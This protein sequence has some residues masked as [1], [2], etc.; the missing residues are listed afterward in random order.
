M[1]NATKY[2]VIEDSTGLIYPVFNYE[3]GQEIITVHLEDGTP[4][5]FTNIDN[6]GDLKNDRYVI[7]EIGTHSQPDGTGTVN[8]LGEPIE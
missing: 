7:R 8:D 2:E 1:N 4:I 6:V 3:A 5:V